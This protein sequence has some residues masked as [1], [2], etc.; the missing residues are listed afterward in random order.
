M[1]TL[2]IYL[3]EKKVSA[4]RIVIGK[5]GCNNGQTCIAPDYII[6]TKAFA[7]TLVRCFT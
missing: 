3:W 1:S 7:P 5:W 2:Y 4:K 6:T